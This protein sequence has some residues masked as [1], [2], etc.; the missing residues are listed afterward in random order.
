MKEKNLLDSRTHVNSRSFVDSKHNLL[1]SELKLLY[2]ATTRTRKRLWI[3][4]DG[5]D[6]SVPMFDY[7]RKKNLVQFE[8]LDSSTADKMK[9]TSSDEEWRS[10]GMKVMIILT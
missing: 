8:M 1:C 4:E 3:C 2:V 10:R 6:F 7:W 5:E 9:V